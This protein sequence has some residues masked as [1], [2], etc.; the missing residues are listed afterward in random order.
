MAVRSTPMHVTMVIATVLLRRP[1]PPSVA[2]DMPQGSKAS[3][4]PGIRNSKLDNILNHIYPGET[5]RTWVGS[6]RLLRP[7]VTSFEPA[8]RRKGFTTRSRR[9]RIW[10]AS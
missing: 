8:C 4:P 2:P 7:C 9:S 1:L 3:K 6:G 10:L 5:D